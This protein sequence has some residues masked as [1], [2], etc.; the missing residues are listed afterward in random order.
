VVDG[1][2]QAEETEESA[3]PQASTER[4][5]D[6]E[7]PTLLTETCIYEGRT[8]HEIAALSGHVSISKFLRDRAYPS[9]PKGLIAAV[10]SSSFQTM[11]TGGTGNAVPFGEKYCE[12]RLST[13][14][15]RFNGR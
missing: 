10:N 9:A 2:L 4:H 14:R 11:S 13:S 7:E 1:V 6:R 8:G 5:I 3:L 12:I 15:S